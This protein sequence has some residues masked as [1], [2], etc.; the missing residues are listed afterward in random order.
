MDTRLDAA[1]AAQSTTAHVVDHII[2]CRPNLTL[3]GAYD[4]SPVVV[5][6]P[7]GTE[8][9]GCYRVHRFGR[10]PYCGCRRD[11]RCHQCDEVSDAAH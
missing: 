7:D 4:T 11:Q 8:C 2:C 6:E 3:C 1:P 5:A 9:P 10:C